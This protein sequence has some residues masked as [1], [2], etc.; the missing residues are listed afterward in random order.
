MAPARATIS[1]IPAW[2]GGRRH[3]AALT[4]E[5]EDARPRLDAWNSV[6]SL[7]AMSV[8]YQLTFRLRDSRVIAPTVTA[9]RRIARSFLEI[10]DRYG[11]LAF[12]V[13]GDHAHAEVVCKREEAG[14]AAQAIG[15]SITQALGLPDGF[16]I[17]HLAA[18]VDQS[19]LEEVFHYVLRQGQKHGLTDDLVHDGSAL[20]DLLDYRVLG[21]GIE[22]RVCAYLPRVSREA[23]RRH[24]GIEPAEL[25]FA[26]RHLADAAAAAFG[27]ANLNGQTE[28]PLLARAA[29]VKIA[30][31]HMKPDAV[32]ALLRVSRS[33]MYA[34]REAVVPAGVILAIRRGMTLRASLG[35]RLMQKLPPTSHPGR[36]T[37]GAP[38]ASSFDA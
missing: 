12:R 17:T 5:A 1:G 13:A 38:S 20:P 11:L 10:G 31:E 22:E 37:R 8:G 27:L 24:L 21:I 34:A 3:R 6:T 7:A 28:V 16:N 23:I 32:V 29:A 36:A 30:T 4:L 14:R 25:V 33:R 19:H 26:P 15:S 35:D 9:R 18:I 2:R